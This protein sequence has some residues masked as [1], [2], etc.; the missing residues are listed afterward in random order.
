MHGPYTLSALSGATLVSLFLHVDFLR[1]DSMLDV[2]ICGQP[3]A[4]HPAVNFMKGSKEYAGSRLFELMTR[5]YLD[6]T[7]RTV[8]TMSSGVGA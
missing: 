8:P 6:G 4:D 2:S 5:Y 3:L 7:Q 1:F